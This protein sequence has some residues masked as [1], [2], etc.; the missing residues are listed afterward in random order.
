MSYL[1]IDVG[2]DRALLGSFG[3]LSHVVS[4]RLM[5]V[6][7][8]FL[9][10]SSG[11]Q[12][13]PSACRCIR[14]PVVTGQP[15]TATLRCNSRI[16]PFGRTSPSS[17][18]AYIIQPPG[19]GAAMSILRQTDDAGQRTTHSHFLLRYIPQSCPSPPHRTGKPA[20]LTSD[21]SDVA[22]TAVAACRVHPFIR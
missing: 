14:M 6:E 5:P 22:C 11:K 2:R 15:R 10:V 12:D 16:I 17:Q 13:R 18:T 3:L 19:P 21:C 9:F 4:Q 20:E 8:V 7:S 1:G